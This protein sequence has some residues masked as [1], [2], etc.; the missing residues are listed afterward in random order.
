MV[1][2]RRK[3]RTMGECFR[4]HASDPERIK[5]AVRSGDQCEASK[6]GVRCE[7]AATEFHDDECCR[8]G[9]VVDADLTLHLC[10]E[11]HERAHGENR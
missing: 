2:P 8:K 6:G 7:Y 10:R 11:C 4:F 1:A 9:L 3:R 5:V